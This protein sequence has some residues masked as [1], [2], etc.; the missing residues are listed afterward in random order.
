MRLK[1]NLCVF[2]LI[3]IGRRIIHHDVSCVTKR[4]ANVNI[5]GTDSSFRGKSQRPSDDL[6]S[7]CFYLCIVRLEAYIY[8]ADLLN[9]RL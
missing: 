3:Y 8:S 7:V 5:V 9:I 1:C 2:G 6:L 4:L